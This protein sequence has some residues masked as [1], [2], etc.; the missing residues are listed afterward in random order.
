MAR[1]KYALGV[2]LA[3]AV[4]RLVAGLLGAYMKHQSVTWGD[5]WLCLWPVWIIA[6]APTAF[7]T[8]YLIYPWFKRAHAD[9]LRTYEERKKSGS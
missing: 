4:G 2:M 6:G 9:A 5:L 3:L 1:V 8:A 7:I